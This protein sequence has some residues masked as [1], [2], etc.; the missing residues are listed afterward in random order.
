MDNNTIRFIT[1]SISSQNI[2]EKV[3][4][5]THPTDG[6]ILSE[7]EKLTFDQIDD[8]YEDAMDFCLDQVDDLYEDAMN[9]TSRY[10]LTKEEFNRVYDFMR[11]CRNHR[12]QIEKAIA[13]RKTVNQK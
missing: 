4:D 13:R 12:N 10:S 7:F 6:E 3:I 2:V 5:N 11:L 8:L 9:S 1:T